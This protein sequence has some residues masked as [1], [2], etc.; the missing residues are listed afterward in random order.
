MNGRE[1]RALRE[2]GRDAWNDWA[3]QILKSKAN[4]QDVGA[5]ALN[6]YGEAD[7]DETR[8]WLKVANADFSNEHFEDEIDFEGFIF[9]GSVNLS[10][11]VFDRPVS[12]AGAE[13]QLPVNFSH[14]QFH[15]DATFKGAKFSGQA[16]FD[17]VVFDGLADFERTE[18]LK[19]K[20]GPLTHSVRF[21]RARFVGKADFRSSVMIGSADFSKA[22][23]AGTARFDETRFTA[24]TVFEGAVFSAPAGFHA[25][26]FFG[27]AA[28]K[29]TQFT[30]EARFA[31]AAFKGESHFERSQFWNDASFR[32]ASF[33]SSALFTDMRVEGASR[34]KGAKFAMEAN[35]LDA[36]FT[37]NA[38]FSD[39]DFGG[40]SIFR[41]AHFAQ[42]ASWECCRF[43]NGGDFSGL[44]LGKASS[45]KAS[46]FEGDAMFR[47][48]HCDATVSFAGA[49][50]RANADFSAFQSKAAVMLANAD[51]KA[52]PDFLQASFLEPPRLDN[53]T[54]ADPVKRFPKL[55]E[56]G[57]SDPRRFLKVMRVCADADA[58]LK[59]RRLKKLAFEAQDLT[60]EQEFFAQ[61][62]RCRR[63]WLDKPFGRGAARFW[64]GWLYGGVSDF[65]RSLVRP[66]LLWLLSIV[67]FAIYFFAQGPGTAW[68]KCAVGSSDP[69][70][71]ALYLAFRNAFLKIDWNDA[72]NARRTLGC[73]YGVEFGGTPVL[74]PAVSAMSLVQASVSVGFILLF[75][76][77]L[78]NLL[79]LR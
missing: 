74:P 21:Q 72:V 70:S 11:A 65:G 19:E 8:L 26:Q 22:Q 23:F 44:T 59:Y 54:V 32:E 50:F 63:F 10:G 9:P 60:R 40:S 47:E 29:E 69:I 37:G 76:L 4:F 61:E 68:T 30:G 16:V 12:F 6:W 35:F 31:E 15:A 57:V 46:Q 7:T 64:F 52:V 18:F 24:D 2:M 3:S 5:F 53:M 67:V 1:M 49:G 41:S 36:R 51:F 45:F 66:F 14:A 56:A 39:A 48:A 17:D 71:E 43:L 13:F 62:L 42:G 79:R 27:A 78:R 28:F 77:A 58:S 73:L 75:V 55:K 34:F 25:S 20:N 38:D 33:D